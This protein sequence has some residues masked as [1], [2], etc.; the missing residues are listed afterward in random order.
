[1]GSGHRSFPKIILRKWRSITEHL[2]WPRSCLGCT[3]RL[4][5][6]LLPVAQAPG[7]RDAAQASCW[8]PRSCSS[9]NNIQ[10]F[11]LPAL[12]LPSCTACFLNVHH[13]LKPLWAP[14]EDIISLQVSRCSRGS[15]LVLKRLPLIMNNLWCSQQRPRPASS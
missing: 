5:I 9:T 11:S 13:C 7:C 12:T 4:E 8:L 15:F 6:S 10:H 2:G 14:A 1:M 3:G